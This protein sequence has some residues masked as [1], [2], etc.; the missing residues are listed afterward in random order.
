M[1]LTELHNTVGFPGMPIYKVNSL[2]L[3]VLVLTSVYEIRKLNWTAL[4]KDLW[5]NK[6]RLQSFIPPCHQTELRTD[7]GPLNS[8]FRESAHREINL[9]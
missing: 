3:R 2:Y 1:L 4:S 8:H 6:R 5:S 7:Y 9:F